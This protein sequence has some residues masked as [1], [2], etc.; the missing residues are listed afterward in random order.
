M[1]KK[2]ALIQAGYSPSVATVHARDIINSDGFKTL[3]KEYHYH[4]DKMGVDVK[5][6]AEKMR[7]GIE[8]EDKKA[9]VLEYLKET[10]RDLGLSKDVPD[11]MIQINISGE[12]QEYAK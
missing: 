9:S 4:L 5:L 1:T 8:G 6:I 7:A 3:Q 2:Q 11:T 10:K 12:L